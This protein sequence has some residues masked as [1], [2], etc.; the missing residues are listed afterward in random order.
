MQYMQKVHLLIPSEA[1]RK[2][3]DNP[4]T[5]EEVQLLTSSFRNCKA[6]GDDGVPMDVQYIN[7]TL[8]VIS[9]NRSI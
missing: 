7:S 3:L 8:I 9:F 1:H 5:L 6:P 2:L 4:F